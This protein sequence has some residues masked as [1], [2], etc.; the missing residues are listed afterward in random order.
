MAC[1]RFATVVIGLTISCYYSVVS[2]TESGNTK[3]RSQTWL[4]YPL[5]ALGGV[6]FFVGWAGFGIWPLEMVTLALFWTALEMVA[7]RACGARLGVGWLYGTVAMAGGYHWMLQFSEAFSGFGS[8]ANAALF[9]GFSL[10]LGLQYGVQGLLYLW[11]R[12]RG[13]SIAVAGL[14]TLVATEWLYPKLFPVYLGNALTDLPI[15]IQIA[16]LGGPLLLSVLVG[17]VNLAVY[18]VF[19]WWLGCRSKPLGFLA[20]AFAFLSLALV[21]GALRIHQVDAR[22]LRAPTIEIGLVQ[23]NMGIF[24]KHEQMLEG[25]QRHLEQSRELEAQGPLDLLIWPE[26]AY[27]YPR[28]GRALPILANEVSADLRTPIL[29]GGLS[30]ARE[31]RYGSLYNSVFLAQDGMIGQR[32]DKTRLAMFGEYLPLGDRFPRLYA[33]SPNSGRFEPGAHLA[34]LSLGPWRISTPI[35]YEDV[36]PGLVREMVAQGN[37]HLLINLTNDAWFGDTQ[38][39]RIHLR[40]AQLRAV[41][42]RRYLVRATNSGVSAVVDPVGRIVVSSAIGSRQ[43]LRASVHLMD[44]QTVYGRLGNWP[45]WVSVLAAGFATALRRRRRS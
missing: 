4:A 6:L 36:L 18:D 22:T 34:P 21:Y 12:A 17:V 8:V 10:Y 29:F 5:A 9:A 38:E 11:L 37:P 20:P 13:T 42:H 24:E 31:G 15:L 2:V 23:A 33:L 32:Y 19:R 16:D 35:C 26:S 28:F 39:P 40:L 41:E 14:S 1:W 43:N 45:G 25:H 44:G 7:D 27:N 3:R 30:F